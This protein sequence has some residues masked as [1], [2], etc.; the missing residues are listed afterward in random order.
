MRIRS[1]PLRHQTGP[2]GGER[3]NVMIEGTGNKTRSQF[4]PL[5]YATICIERNGGEARNE[6]DVPHRSGSVP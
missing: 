5:A 3:K 2:E 6:A 1:R 4:V